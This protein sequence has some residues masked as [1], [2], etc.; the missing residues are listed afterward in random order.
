MGPGWLWL[1]TGVPYELTSKH[2][3]SI[4]GRTGSKRVHPISRLI[5]VLAGTC[6]Q[7]AA[8]VNGEWLPG[9]GWFENLMPLISDPVG[10]LSGPVSMLIAATLA[11]LCA[12]FSWDQ[13]TRRE[14]RGRSRVGKR[15][16]A[17][18]V[19][20]GTGTDLRLVQ[21]GLE[22]KIHTY[23]QGPVTSLLL[24][25]RDLIFQFPDFIIPPKPSQRAVSRAKRAIIHLLSLSFLHILCTKQLF[26]V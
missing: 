26:L 18:S 1:A 13:L 4:E 14:G 24:S 12:C 5:K 16:L 10:T 6:W 8:T 21:P 17:S 19:L 7:R 23:I 25:S 22:S 2:C 3:R 20:L 11:R 15:L 9:M